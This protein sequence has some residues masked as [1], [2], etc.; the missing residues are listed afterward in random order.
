MI[1]T[2]KFQKSATFSTA[3]EANADRV[4]LASSADLESAASI[5][6]ELISSGVLLEA[7]TYS[8]DQPSQTLTITRNVSDLNSYV[9]AKQEVSAKIL[10][11][12]LENG[13]VR[14]KD[15]MSE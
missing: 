5:D 15:M 11:K 2:V 6:A 1:F 9:S 12:V 10:T 8:W 14:T 4:A 7:E 13:W 3:E